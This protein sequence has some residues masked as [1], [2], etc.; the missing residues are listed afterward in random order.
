MPEKVEAE[1]LST[2]ASLAG[3]A[4]S[5]LSLV[6]SQGAPGAARSLPCP[7]YSPH[8][9]VHRDSPK[10]T[11]QHSRLFPW[12]RGEGCAMGQNVKYAPSE[13]V[14]PESNSVTYF[15]RQVK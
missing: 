2:K 10:E 7:P 3:T 5:S 12:R 9:R 4:T 11:L 8:S 6:R 15:A 14:G 13:E 1:L